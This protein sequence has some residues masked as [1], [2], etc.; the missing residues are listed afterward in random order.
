[1]FSAAPTGPAL[2]G[3]SGTVWDYSLG[4]ATVAKSL[5]YHEAPPPPAAAGSDAPATAPGPLPERLGIPD[6]I[7]GVKTWHLAFYAVGGLLIY[8]WLFAG[9]R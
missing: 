8:R 6:T 7:A 9:K 1:M 2:Y 4:D 3:P 5:G